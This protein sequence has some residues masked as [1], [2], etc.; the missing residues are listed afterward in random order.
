MPDLDTLILWHH[1]AIKTMT[2]AS[3][4]AEKISQD[5]VNLIAA[6]PAGTHDLQEIAEQMPNW[7]RSSLRGEVRDQ[8]DLADLAAEERGRERRHAIADAIGG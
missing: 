3:A 2:E 4:Y 6:A 5:I 8:Q 1:N 7:T